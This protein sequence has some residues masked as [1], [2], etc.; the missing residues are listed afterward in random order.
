MKIPDKLAEII[1]QK[2][3]EVDKL[4]DQSSWLKK[5]ALKRNDFRSFRGNLYAPGEMTLIAE[6]KKASPSA[7]DIAPDIIPIEQAQTYETAGAHAL[8][9][10]TD[11]QFFKGD[12]DDLF[13]IR[14][15]VNLPILRKDFIIAADQIYE[16]VI[17]GADAIL[18]IVAALDDKMLYELYNR[19]RDA[20]L[21]V[22]VEVH[23]LR[24]MDR[25]LD[26]EA[27]IIGINN[28]NLH[29]F[30][31]NL[32]TTLDLAEEIPN[33][34]LAVSESGIKTRDDAKALWKAGINTLLVGETL[35]RSGNIAETIADLLGR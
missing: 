28:R 33:D 10:L 30:E 24:E 25:A 19:A 6:V 29:T 17:S 4:K 34:C 11:E 3:Q 32:Q 12:L 20:Q 8:S 9:V 18:L 21:D 16:S 15:E 22:L 13:A 35:M 23:D 31:V 14:K 7:G 5:T 1:A 2:K 27:D 26:I